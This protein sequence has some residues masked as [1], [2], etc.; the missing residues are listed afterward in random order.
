[1]DKILEILNEARPDIDFEEEKELIDGGLLDSFDIVSI[2]SDL[3]DEFD[4]NIRVT[5]LKAENF[6]SVEAIQNL[7]LSKQKEVKS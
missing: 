4:I 2:I 6:N 3:N 7:V 1:M 5:D